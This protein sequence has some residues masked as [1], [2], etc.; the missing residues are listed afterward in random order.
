MVVCFFFMGRTFAAGSRAPFTK[1]YPDH[2]IHIISWVLVLSS[3]SSLTLP[4]DHVLLTILSSSYFISKSVLA[5]DSSNSMFFFPHSFFRVSPTHLSFT[6]EFHNF[7][8]ISMRHSSRIPPQPLLQLAL[9][10]HGFTVYDNDYLNSVHDALP[11]AATTLPS[12]GPVRR[13]LGCI[14]AAT[15]VH[16]ALPALPLR[17][18]LE[19]HVARVV[20]QLR[21][22]VD[23]MDVDA[24]VA[25]DLAV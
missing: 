16:A 24:D 8:H 7:Y 18:L 1:I 19:G 21:I 11:P 5:I 3:S 22:L 13:L 2:L 15:R 12:R 20:R 10:T 17:V 25:I 14:S 4:S 6:I 23:A 9:I